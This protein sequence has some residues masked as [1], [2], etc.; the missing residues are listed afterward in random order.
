MRPQDEGAGDLARRCAE[1]IWARDA[2]ARSMGMRVEDV[3]SGAAKVSMRVR[4]DMLNGLGICHGGVLFALA[5]AACAL[6]C[7]SHNRRTVTRSG[8]IVFV[9][10]ARDGDLL[11]ADAVERLRDGRNGLYD[12]TVSTGAAVVAEFRGRTREVPGA[13]LPGSP[14]A[15]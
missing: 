9:A 14:G 15:S 4:S 1:W 13:L 8:D 7:N 3:R 6:A 10:P 5:D 12:V 11:V 2:A